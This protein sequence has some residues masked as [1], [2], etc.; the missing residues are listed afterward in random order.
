MFP[1]IPSDVARRK[2]AKEEPETGTGEP[3]AKPLTAAEKKKAAAA[4]R[5][6]AKEAEKAAEA[7]GD[8]APQGGT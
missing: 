2:A 7:A 8:D 3:A 4:A 5:K 6:A 1:R